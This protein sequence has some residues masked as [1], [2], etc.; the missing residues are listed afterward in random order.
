MVTWSPRNTVIAAVLL[1]A[2][3]GGVTGLSARYL[4]RPGPTARTRDFYLFG[5]AQS[6]NSTLASGLRGDYAFSSSA[7]NVNTGDTLVIRSLNPTEAS[8]T[9]T[10]G[11]PC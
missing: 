9:V 6:F 1:S 2:L 4:S 10:N 7:I 3:V 8:T 5:V 11:S